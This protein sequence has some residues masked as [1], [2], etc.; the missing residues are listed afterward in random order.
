MALGNMR[1]NSVRTLAVWPTASHLDPI[2]D[3]AG[4]YSDQDRGTREP[5]ARALARAYRPLRGGMRW[6]TR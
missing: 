4:L 3:I 1:A 2:L 5:L 6:E